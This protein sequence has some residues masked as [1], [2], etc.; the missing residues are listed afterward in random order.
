VE[1]DRFGLNGGSYSTFAYAKDNPLK[2]IDPEG[3]LSGVV[4][5]CVCSYMKSN[6]YEGCVFALIG[7]LSALSFWLTWK[8][9]G[10]PETGTAPTV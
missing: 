7:T 6:G 1:S 5:S 4:A 10:I 8:S 3:L 9:R 2:Y